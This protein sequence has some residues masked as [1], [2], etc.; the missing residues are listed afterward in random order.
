MT[1]AKQAE[2]QYWKYRNFCL[3]TD[4]K[5]GEWVEMRDMLFH[6]GN[7]FARDVAKCMNLMQHYYS[8]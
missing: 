6:S 4:F 1:S 2:I 3:P 7:K 5:M 8:E